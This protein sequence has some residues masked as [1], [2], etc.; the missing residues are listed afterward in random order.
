M[1]KARFIKHTLVFKRPSAT[2]RGVLTTKDSWFLILT[3]KDK[4][5]IGECSILKG[6][7]HDDQPDFVG[8][9]DIVSDFVE[10]AEI[11]LI[12]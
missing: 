3:E 10:F 4:S 1:I 8:I 5:G 2:S 7:S 9:Y 12:V 11:F 6:L